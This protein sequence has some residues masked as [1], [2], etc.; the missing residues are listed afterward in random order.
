MISIDLEGEPIA[1]PPEAAVDL[2]VDEHRALRLAGH[3]H[4]IMCTIY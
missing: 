2:V 1:S 4:N 3:G